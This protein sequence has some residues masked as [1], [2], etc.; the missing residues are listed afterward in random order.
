MSYGYL[1]IFLLNFKE[2]V[3]HFLILKKMLTV[4]VPRFPLEPEESVISSF[5]DDLH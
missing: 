5:L 1:Y 2:I 3:Y 4:A